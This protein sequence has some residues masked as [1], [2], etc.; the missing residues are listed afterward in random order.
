MATAAATTAIA[1]VHANY[2]TELINTVH[3]HIHSAIAPVYTHHVAPLIAAHVQPLLHQHVLPAIATYVTPHAV[4]ASAHWQHVLKQ[5]PEH[6]QQ[7]FGEFT[8]TEVNKV[9]HK[10]PT[11][12]WIIVAGKAKQ[13]QQT[14][15]R[16]HATTATHK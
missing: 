12:Q 7:R 6:W 10:I 8:L 15:T 11:E 9:L 4:V 14:I 1:F 5:M 2:P 3:H 13:Q 16:G